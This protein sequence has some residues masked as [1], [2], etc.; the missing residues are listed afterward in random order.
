MHN[1]VF[2]CTEL[3]FKAK[4]I[5]RTLVELLLTTD[6]CVR[7]SGCGLAKRATPGTIEQKPQKYMTENAMH[8]WKQF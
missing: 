1:G 8:F 6:A 3:V 5:Q 7:Q 4:Q 2:G